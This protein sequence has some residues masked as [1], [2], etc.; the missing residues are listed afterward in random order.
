[1]R[2]I[3]KRV[4]LPITGISILFS[5]L[6]I[7]L[8]ATVSFS[9][10]F[11]Y[12]HNTEET[13]ISTDE[14]VATKSINADGEIASSP[15]TRPAN[16]EEQ[17]NLYTEIPGVGAFFGSMLDS[18]INLTKDSENHC[19]LLTHHLPLVFPDLYKVLVTL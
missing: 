2:T 13:P 9:S 19:Q 16:A 4:L 11:S 1:M 18:L 6:L 10:I 3:I 17:T 14:N 8:T 15:G 7:V 5:L 12:T